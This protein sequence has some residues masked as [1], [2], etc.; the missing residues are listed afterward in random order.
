MSNPNGLIWSVPGRACFEPSIVRPSNR[1]PQIV[2]MHAYDWW[3]WREKERRKKWS[4]VVRIRH[5]RLSWHAQAPSFP[6]HIWTGF[7]VRGQ[8]RHMRMIY[9]VWLGSLF[10]SFSCP[11]TIQAVHPD[12]WG[13]F[14]VTGWRCSN[15]VNEGGKLSQ[16]EWLEAVSRLQLSK[17]LCGVLLCIVA[18]ADA[19]STSN[20]YIG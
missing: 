10:P 2:R 7:E 6:P 3:G 5:G 14:E 11:S 9:E 16:L 19:S 18:L 15:Q 17:I 8:L 12:I 1:V 13:G 20:G 4:R